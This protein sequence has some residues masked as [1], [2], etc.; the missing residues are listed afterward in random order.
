MTEVVIDASVVLAAVAQ[1]TGHDAIYSHDT[2]LI[3]AV[4][5]A[6]VHA[7]LTD[8]GYEKDAAKASLALFDLTVVDF[9]AEQ[10]LVSAELR[11]ATRQMG[12]SLGD[13]ACLALAMAREAK[14]LTADHAWGRAEL[15]LDIDFIR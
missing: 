9:T 11:P 12:L 13:R 7:K 1:E 10:A 3:S 4:N 2:P 8:W 5:Y 6:E 14:V 15:N